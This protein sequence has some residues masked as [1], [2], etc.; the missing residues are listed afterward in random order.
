MLQLEEEVLG[1]GGLVTEGGGGGEGRVIYHSPHGRGRINN[2]F[3]DYGLQWCFWLLSLR[4]RNSF[5]D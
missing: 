1:G 2:Y 4:I 5:S 3:L